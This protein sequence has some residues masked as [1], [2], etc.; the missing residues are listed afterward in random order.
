MVDIATDKGISQPT[1]SRRIESGVEKL[2]ERLRRRGII[3]ALATLGG[4]LGEN[5]VE[6]APALVLKELG[7]MALVGGTA[8]A[9]GVGSAAATSGAGAKAAV[10]VL[11]GVKAKVVT[12]AVVT[13]VGVGGVATYQHVTQPVEP[14]EKRVTEKAKY[15]ELQ[16]S[17]S[18]SL[19]QRSGQNSRV[20]RGPERVTVDTEGVQQS[21]NIASSSSVESASRRSIRE[22]ASIGSSVSRFADGPG[23]APTGGRMTG[24]GVASSAGGDSSDA[25]TD[26]AMGFYSVGYGGY[27]GGGGRYGEVREDPNSADDD[28]SSENRR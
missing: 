10:G 28:S 6:A 21:E 17:A 13:V 1:V 7:K 25:D 24:G 16:R 27:G 20:V 2:R 15:P 14:V 12:A 23:E 26:E 9:S 8:A 4:L 5:V 11:A 18:S 19:T 3:V 22:R